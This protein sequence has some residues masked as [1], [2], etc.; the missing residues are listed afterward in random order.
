M[1]WSFSFLQLVIGNYETYTTI[2]HSLRPIN[3]VRYLRLEPQTWIGDIAVRIELY[4]TKEMGECFKSSANFSIFFVSLF[5]CL[6]KVH[7]GN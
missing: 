5:P 7:K 4:G 2:R 1:N 3:N 6:I